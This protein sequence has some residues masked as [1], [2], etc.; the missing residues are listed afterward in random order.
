MFVGYF[1][2]LQDIDDR[3]QDDPVGMDV[4]QLSIGQVLGTDVLDITCNTV[5][6]QPF[7]LVNIGRGQPPGCLVDVAGVG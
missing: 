6:T 7:V 1:D 4:C 2:R 5:E 3:A